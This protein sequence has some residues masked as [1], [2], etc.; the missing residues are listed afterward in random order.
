MRH[1]F[2]ADMGGIILV[3]PD[4]HPFPVTAYQ[5]NDLILKGHIFYP[6]LS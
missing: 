3:C 5:L 1:A 2:F 6:G 4:F